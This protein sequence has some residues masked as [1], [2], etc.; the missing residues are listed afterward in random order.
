MWTFHKYSWFWYRNVEFFGDLYLINAIHKPSTY[1][2]NH[3]FD[4]S[5]EKTSDD[6]IVYCSILICVSQ[7]RMKS[8]EDLHVTYLCLVK[9]ITVS[10]S[11]LFPLSQTVF[12]ASFT[13]VVCM[14]CMFM[15]IP[16]SFWKGSVR[17]FLSIYSELLFSL[18]RTEWY[19]FLAIRVTP[20]LFISIYT[21][22]RF[23]IMTKYHTS[24]KTRVE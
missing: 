7:P 12:Y 13:G 22:I 9:S 20:L 4:E 18:C 17:V 3:F 10:L 16:I 15:L 5:K 14:F 1:I 19:W 8:W 11:L 24:L 23:M 21:H 2:A 6:E